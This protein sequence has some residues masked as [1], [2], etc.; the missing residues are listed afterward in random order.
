MTAITPTI[1]EADL[2]SSYAAITGPESS[3]LPLPELL[4]LSF[5]VFDRT[6]NADDNNG[7]KRKFHRRMTEMNIAARQE[8]EVALEA[9]IDL[10]LPRFEQHPD[11]TARARQILL[12]TAAEIEQLWI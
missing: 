9:L 11:I 6:K 2:N 5:R 4:R 12:T 10:A 8:V 3:T 1:D 7:S